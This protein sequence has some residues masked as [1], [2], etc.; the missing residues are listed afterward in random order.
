M[1]AERAG[2]KEWFEKNPS[3]LSPITGLALPSAVL[4]TNWSLRT[5]IS[6]SMEGAAAGKDTIPGATT[7]LARSSRERARA[8]AAAL[9]AAAHPHPLPA[10]L[11]NGL[12]AQRAAVQEG[13]GSHGGG[14]QGSDR[15]AADL[16]DLR[17]GPEPS[18]AADA[19]G[20][21]SQGVATAAAR[22]GAGGSR[23]SEE[24]GG[25]GVAAAAAHVLG[26]PRRES[27]SAL[28]A[29]GGAAAAGSAGPVVEADLVE[30]FRR[31]RG[32]R[33]AQPP[34]PEEA[35]QE[36]D[37][38]EERS[39]PHQLGAGAAGPVV[40]SSCIP[41]LR[42]SGGAGGGWSTRVSR[43]SI[44]LETLDTPATLVRPLAVQRAAQPTC[45]RARSTYNRY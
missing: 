37:A 44:R 43:A 30:Y 1:A 12:S 7:R 10:A 20:L 4:T 23:S 19:A 15:H 42:G 14:E 29:V 18:S 36:A 25:S 26:R 9:E 40:E 6:D 33:L 34:A 38:E 39:I 5:L 2:I 31:G 11:G 17:G 3:L 8:A 32:D 21:R 45:R 13:A 24:G 28:E 16:R 35:W 27:W 22:S 41:L